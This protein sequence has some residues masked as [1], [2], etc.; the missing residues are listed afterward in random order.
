MKT[1]LF[2]R[3]TSEIGFPKENHKDNIP[4]NLIAFK[5]WLKTNLHLPKSIII[6]W[7]IEEYNSKVL[8]GWA[9][10]GRYV[11]HLI[12]PRS[13]NSGHE[14]VLQS[15]LKNDIGKIRSDLALFLCAFWI[16]NDY[17]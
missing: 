2:R 5:N 6:N 13:I 8:I 10:M 12:I 1:T 7:I 4:C 16:W 15:F 17:N 9:V 3:Q 11:S 14:I